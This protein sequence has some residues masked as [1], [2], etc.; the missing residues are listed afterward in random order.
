MRITDTPNTA[1]NL[2]TAL[3]SF[4]ELQAQLEAQSADLRRDSHRDTLA[5]LRGSFGR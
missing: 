2:R 3:G 1:Q 5:P 4:A